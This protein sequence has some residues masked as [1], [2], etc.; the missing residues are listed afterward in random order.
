[1]TRTYKIWRKLI[2][3]PHKL[4]VENRVFNS[5]CVIT[6]IMLLLVIVVNFNLQLNSSLYINT[7]VLFI[8]L[9]IYY[10]S[11][12]KK[13]YRV[14]ILLYAFCTYATLFVNYFY[15]GG[16]E[17]PTIL[18]F[19]LT[20]QLLI[21][22]SKRS[23]HILWTTL[24]ITVALVLILIEYF[25]PDS[26]QVHY[27]S[28]QEHY[29]DIIST[30][31]ICLF[32]IYIITIHLRNSYYRE[33]L[34]AQQ[35]SVEIKKH[36]KEIEE[37]NEKLKEIAWMQSHKV[38]GQVATILG[39]CQFVDEHKEEDPH[40]REVLEGIKTA[41]HDLDEVIKEINELTKK[42]EIHNDIDKH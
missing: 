20:F 31:V 6:T 25:Y 15:N 7:G 10:I 16:I 9:F 17:G 33:K 36:L 41:T 5:V 24:H 29:L 21:A 14:G 42:A 34:L 27:L 23:Q 11:R 39:L 1:M 19:F 12:F 30:Y 32:F 22:I 35:R 4:S 38:R 37:Q 28:K 2:G 13:Q 3:H 18:A 40:T 8:Q 26:I